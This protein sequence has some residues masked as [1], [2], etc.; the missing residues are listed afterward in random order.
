MAIFLNFAIQEKVDVTTGTKLA[1]RWRNDMTT[2]GAQRPTSEISEQIDDTLQL[3]DMVRKNHHLNISAG[4]LHS[5]S[6]DVTGELVQCEE[7]SVR[8]PG[9]CL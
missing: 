8:T 6:V 4:F 9:T 7:S 3:E 2:K 1:W 5:E